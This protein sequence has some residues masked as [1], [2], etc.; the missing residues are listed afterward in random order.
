MEI[1]N[2]L[3]MPIANKHKDKELWEVS[4]KFEG[5]L[6]SQLLAEMS[7][8]VPTSS[9]SSGS[10]FAEDVHKS[11][12]TQAVADQAVKSP[13]LGIAESIYRQMSKETNEISDKYKGDRD[14]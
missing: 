2:D 7:K 5:M 11:L 12:F 14:E 6:I 3:K 10:G 4:K 9:S 8:T 1:K 13:S